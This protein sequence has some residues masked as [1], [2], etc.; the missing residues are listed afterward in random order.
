MYLQTQTPEG[1]PGNFNYN[2]NIPI[3][4]PT[5]TWFHD[6]PCAALMLVWPMSVPH[7]SCTKATRVSESPKLFLFRLALSHLL[8]LGENVLGS[9]YFWVPIAEHNIRCYSL[10]T[11]WSLQYEQRHV[12]LMYTEYLGTR[13]ETDSN[14]CGVQKYVSS[15]N[16]HLLH[17]TPP[18]VPYFLGEI[19]LN[20]VTRE[21]IS[22]F[23]F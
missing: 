17:F 9:H 13:V 6:S 4:H 8:L 18:K 22:L 7:L 5:L 21:S 3:V 23:W 12:F 15:K 1:N 20:S 16:K 10:M 11:S 19:P 14:F 2:F